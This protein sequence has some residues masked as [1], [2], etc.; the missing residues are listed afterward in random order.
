[1]SA[2]VVRE[3]SI[4]EEILHV[5]SHGAGVLFSIVAL[6]LLGAKAAGSSHPDALLAAGLF[7]FGMILMFMT[8]TLYHAA[9]KSPFQ[10]FLKMLDHAAI[11]LMIAGSYSPYALLILAP[12]VGMML[13]ISMWSVA[14]FGVAFK[15]V[16]FLVDKQHQFKWLSLSI[17]LAMGWGGV[18]V[19]KWL[20]ELLPGAGFFWLAAS[21]I[22]YTI[23]AFIY[24]AKSIKYTHAIWHVMVVVASGFAFISIYGYVL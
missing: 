6:V 15:I 2:K 5:L 17:Y 20:Y 11:Y 21:G 23:G 8:S 16:M 24:A 4:G 19:M 3:Y 7:G 10:P 14:A 9:Y 12:D 13:L 1:M 18:V 22:C